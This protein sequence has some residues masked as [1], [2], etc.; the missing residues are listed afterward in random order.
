M[1]LRKVKMNSRVKRLNHICLGSTNLEEVEAFYCGFLGCSIIHEFINPA[2]E[3]YGFIIASGNGISI[4]FFNQQVPVIGDGLFRH[5][6]FE[7]EDIIQIAESLKE[8]GYKVDVT[9]GKTDNVLQCWMDG[10]DG[11]K[12]EFHQ[13]DAQSKQ[14]QEPR[15]KDK[16]ACA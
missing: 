7:V 13:Y 10:P 9:R 4:E 3:R 1:K 5:L 11:I 16:P 15:H 12:I 14:Y 8:L 6:C 2:G